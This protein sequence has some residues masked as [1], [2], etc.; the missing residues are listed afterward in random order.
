MVVALDAILVRSMLFE[1]EVLRAIE[2]QRELSVKA[3]SDGKHVAKLNIQHLEER[4]KQIRA[5]KK[6][7]DERVTQRQADTDARIKARQEAADAALK[8]E[9][10]LTFMNGSPAATESDFERLF[11]SLRDEYLLEKHRTAMAQA[12][13]RIRP[14]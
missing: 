14:L 2:N 3:D 11:P 12:R 8:E 7:R 4:L 9:M 1:S 13:A 10:R 5:R 6:A